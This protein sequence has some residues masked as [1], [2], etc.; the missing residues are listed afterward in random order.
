M[1]LWSGQ[2]VS[3]IG[4][5]VSALAFPLLVLAL[6]NSPAKAGI[7]G[8]AQSLPNLFLY[9]IAGVLVDRWDRKLIM[10]F[11]DV[12]RALA[13][14]SIAVALVSG[15]LAFAHI[16][17]VAFVEGSLG[18]FFRVAE[19]AALPQVVP[20]QQLPTAIAQNQ[21]R[22]QGAGIVSQPLAGFLFSI[23]RSVP[24][25]FD[26]ISYTASVV[27][28][29]FIR[30]KFQQMRERSLTSVRSQMAEGIRWLLN[31]P[32]LRTSIVLSAATNFAHSALALILIV[33]A[34]QFGASPT[35]IG[36]MFGLFAGGAVVGALVAPWVQRNVAPPVLLIGAIWLWAVATAAL[37]LVHNTIALGVLAGAQA[38]VGPSWNVIV[39]SYRYALVPDRLLGRV[40][41]AGALVSWGTIPLGSLAAGLLIEAT[42]TRT[43]FL[44]LAAVF[45][46]TAIAATSA[47]TMREAPR[48][49]TL[50]RRAD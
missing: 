10:V 7:V 1:L 47:K 20:K 31:E 13:L 49:E 39:G 12:V 44:I 17:L 18:V 23:G 46:V 29:L 14:G 9:L 24:F 36:V 34:Q 6:T 27:S 45:L 15:H 5:E 4:S 37:V 40:Q 33:R 8:F 50:L 42:G 22:Q 26:A 2:V 11:A 21:A 38:L 19:S 3:T 48:I 30:P 16:I 41:S 43:S 25:L 32:F 28:L 35:L